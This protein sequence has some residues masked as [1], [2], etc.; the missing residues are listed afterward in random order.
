M[1]F[2]IATVVMSV[3]ME[4]VFQVFIDDFWPCFRIAITNYTFVINA[5]HFVAKRNTSTVNMVLVINK[6]D[7]FVMT[8]GLAKHAPNTV[9]TS[10]S[11]NSHFTLLK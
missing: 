9:T 10:H 4:S 6:K 11:L 5:T 8:V 3:K 1:A 2:K 7:A